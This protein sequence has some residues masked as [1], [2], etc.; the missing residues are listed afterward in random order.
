MIFINLTPRVIESENESKKCGDC[1][2]FEKCE[3]NTAEEVC[4]DEQSMQAQPNDPA[5]EH[6]CDKPRER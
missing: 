6:Y 5:C 4:F 1:L 2:Y 3:A